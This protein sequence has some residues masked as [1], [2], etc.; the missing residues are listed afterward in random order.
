[1]SHFNFELKSSEN[2]CQLKLIARESIKL[3]PPHS[4][5]LSPSNLP[6]SGVQTKQLIAAY[7]MVPAGLDFTP[8]YSL[9]S[10]IQ[11]YGNFQDSVLEP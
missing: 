10:I 2:I 6:Q 9:V 8:P 7:L 3:L 1:M 4:L 11:R 5:L